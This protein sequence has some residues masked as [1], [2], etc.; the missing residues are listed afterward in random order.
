MIDHGAFPE[1]Q[2][3][4]ATML[5]A[6]ARD[7]VPFGIEQID[8]LLRLLSASEPFETFLCFGADLT[9]LASA[10]L[11][12]YP[13]AH[14][15]LMV[16][17]DGAMQRAA[18]HLQTHERRHDLDLGTIR[19]VKPLDESALAPYSAIIIGTVVDRLG[20]DRRGLYEECMRV[21]RPGGLVINVGPVASATRWTESVFDD[22]MIDA[23]FGE[24][25]RHGEGKSRAEIAREH[26]ERTGAGFRSLAVP[27]E[28]Q[29]DWMRDIGFGNVDV[30]S[31]I[32]ELAVYGGQKPNS[33][34][35]S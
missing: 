17:S 29:C 23:I 8:I 5:L 25:L 1:N 2:P 22:Y 7:E 18:V 28:V 20:L 11:D 27:L 16:C 14:G 6:Q 19:D 33:P 26:F 34:V 32:A 12:E 9:M 24:E 30:Y 4:L 35:R 15:R 10:I 31:K 21:L 13:N 3:D